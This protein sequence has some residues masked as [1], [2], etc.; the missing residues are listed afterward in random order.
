MPPTG[1][2]H[3]AESIEKMR[4]NQKGKNSGKVRSAEFKDNA[5][6]KLKGIKR[7][8]ETRLKMSAAAKLRDNS[9]MR[10]PEVRIRVGIAIRGRVSPS[11]GVPMPPQT[12][13]ALLKSVKGVP[14]SH[15]HRE[16]MS[17]DRKGDKCHF[18]RGGIH[19]TN[20]IERARAMRTFQYRDWKA[21][22][23][24]RDA[25]ACVLQD[26]TCSG[27]LQADHIKP[28]STYPEL[29]YD[30]SNGRVLCESHHRR[31]PTYG[32]KGLKYKKSS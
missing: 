27:R 13:E 25:H 9:A 30:V 1:H 32:G 24:E 18:W 17:L 5:S 11:K 14:K 31:T 22:V 19:E 15:E 4:R 3:T 28:W 20:Q 26:E 2:K 23:F 21:Q 10:S 6:A 16:K 8:A 29:R 7:S 12:R